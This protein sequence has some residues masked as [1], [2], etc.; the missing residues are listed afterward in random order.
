MPLRRV[1]SIRY[2]TGSSPTLGRP[3]VRTRRTLHQFPVIAEQ[4][5]EVAV[6]PLHRVRGPCA[7][8][9]TADRVDTLAAAIGVLP[10]EAL[11]PDLA[12]FALRPTVLAP[13]PPPM[14]F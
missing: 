6:V 14:A 7:F 2:R 5:V 3:L 4:G 8:Q 12:A 11:F 1:V 10:A 9:P 13:L